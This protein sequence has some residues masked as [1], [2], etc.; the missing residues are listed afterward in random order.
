MQPDFLA[1]LLDR[2]RR[3]RIHTAVD[4]SGFAPED[5]FSDIAARTD[6]LLFDLKIMDDGA[7]QRYTGVSNRR[8]LDNLTAAAHAGHR[9]RIRVPVIPGITD[10]EDNLCRIADFLQPFEHVRDVDLLPFH[11]IADGKYSRLGLENRMTATRSPSRDTMKRVA[12]TFKSRGFNVSSG[13]KP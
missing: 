2:C 7:H 3:E 12:R 13:G 4:T 8:I 10:G 1:A 6:L 9:L 11:R 5:T